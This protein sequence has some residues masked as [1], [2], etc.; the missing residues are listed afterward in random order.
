M[1]LL[2]PH[3][4]PCLVIMVN[5]QRIGLVAPCSYPQEKAGAPTSQPK[6][7]HTLYYANKVNRNEIFAA[8]AEWL[9]DCNCVFV[10]QVATARRQRRNLSVIKLSPV[11]HTRWR[12]HTVFLMLNIKQ[13]SSEY[14]FLSS[15]LTRPGIEP[16]STV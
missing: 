12:L 2:L 13:G 8:S 16:E 3:Y 6:S 1:K 4:F 7:F 9:Y 10:P 15:D 14:Q 5:R 11:Y